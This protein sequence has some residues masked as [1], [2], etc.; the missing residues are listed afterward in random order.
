MEIVFANRVD[1]RRFPLSDERFTSVVK[2][3]DNAIALDYHFW[4]QL[5]YWSDV[6]QEKIFMASL[7]GSHVKEIVTTGLV[8]TGDEKNRISFMQHMPF[9]C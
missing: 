4:R 8:S 9:V 1:I 2:Q 3:L 6:T 7:N 5:L